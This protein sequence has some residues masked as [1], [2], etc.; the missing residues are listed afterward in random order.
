V[1]KGPGA[2]LPPAPPN[3]QHL[4]GR[5]V[6]ISVHRGGTEDY[7]VGL[8]LG[9]CVV[10]GLRDAARQVRDSSVYRSTYAASLGAS[11]VKV[12]LFKDE[13]AIKPGAWKKLGRLWE[14]GWWGPL[15]E[16]KGKRTFLLP[17]TVVFRGWGLDPKRRANDKGRRNAAAVAEVLMKA[18]A[19]EAGV[20]FDALKEGKAGQLGRFTTVS[21]IEAEPGRGALDL[22]RGNVLLPRDFTRAQAMDV[23]VKSAENLI[24]HQK[25][26]GTYGYWY[27]T[28][29]DKFSSEYGVPRHAGT[30]WGLFRMYNVTGD[31]RFLDSAKKGLDWMVRQVETPADKP[32]L[33]VIKTGRSAALGTQ[34]LCLMALIEMPKAEMTPELT[35]LQDRL[36]E[37]LLFM[38][39]EDGRVYAD[40][41]QAEAR[42]LP[43]EQPIYYPGESALALIML[44][45]KDGKPKWLAGARRIVDFQV[46]EFKR[47]G[48]PDNW[49]IQ[50]LSRLYRITKE[51]TYLEYGFKTADYN[52]AAQWQPQEIKGVNEIPYYDYVGGFNNSTPPR[53]T[54][55]GSRIEAMDE[56]YALA[57]FAKDEAAMKRYG[58][59]IWQSMW[60]MMN[61]QYRPENAFFVR[62]PEAAM[63]GMKGGL[64]DN[65][66]RIDFNQHIIMALLG[67]LVVFDDRPG[68]L[69]STVF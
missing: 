44:H 36:G 61:H 64:I 10:D 11:R 14:P 28:D 8:G 45:E 58:D 65:N 43:A 57:K 16:A 60:F 37:T 17:D 12:D 33:A 25:D 1:E 20:E 5:E 4:C 49:I 26:D 66:I 27:M 31:K 68:V 22:V 56:A 51:P 48:V 42:R 41:A 40:Y 52:I 67:G 55:A 62:N 50:D 15:A 46:G 54:P 6:W 35:A 2:E 63:G 3:V 19:Q 69:T 30:V 24:R 38:A 13:E 9:D 32:A 21:F 34:A 18:L 39:A 29:V 23:V 53:S 59:S 47:T 7:A